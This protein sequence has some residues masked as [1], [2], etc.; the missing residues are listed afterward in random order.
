V[1]QATQII[2]VGISV[3]MNKKFL[4]PFD[5]SGAFK[6]NNIRPDELRDERCDVALPNKFRAIVAQGNN[7]G[8]AC[9]EYLF[10]PTSHQ[11]P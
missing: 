3:N 6:V 2:G 4:K 1:N 7:G 8:V 10:N 11:S 5:L 9:G